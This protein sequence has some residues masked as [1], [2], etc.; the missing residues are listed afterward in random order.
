M[1]SKT[2]KGEI[3][4][5]KAGTYYSSDDIT[6]LI[7]SKSD[8]QIFIDV[9]DDDLNIFFHFGIGDDNVC[10]EFGDPYRENDS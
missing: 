4:G 5:L 8:D 6:R 3:R 2:N 9:V 10:F 1:D 7:V